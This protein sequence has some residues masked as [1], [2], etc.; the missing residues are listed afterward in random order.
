MH[1]PYATAQTPAPTLRVNANTTNTLQSADTTQPVN[2][3]TPQSGI[4]PKAAA[5]S[6]VRRNY[7]WL[8]RIQVHDVNPH[9]RTSRPPSTLLRETYRQAP[10]QQTRKQTSSVLSN[11]KTTSYPADATTPHLQL[12]VLL[13]TGDTRTSRHPRAQILLHND[14]NRPLRHPQIQVLLNTGGTRTSLHTQDKTQP[15][16]QGI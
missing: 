1:A 4:P 11:R 14:D 8:R 9:R 16:Q 12:Q 13:N 3:F 10:T 6:T 7:A 15:Q 2:S 5:H